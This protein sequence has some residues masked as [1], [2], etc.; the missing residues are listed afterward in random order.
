MVDYLAFPPREPDFYTRISLRKYSRPLPF[1]SQPK[2]KTE[3][4]IRLPIPLSLS[5]SYN[6]DVNNHEYGML[7]VKDPYAALAAGDTKADE[8]MREMSAAEGFGVGRVLSNAVLEVAALMPGV[9]D[10]GFG[11]TAQSIK[12]VVRNPHLTTIFEGVK[13]RAFSF[14]WKLA[15]KSK[16]EAREINN[17]IKTLK[18]YMH[19]QIIAGGFALDYPYIAAMEIVNTSSII[20][21]VKDSFITHLD[22]SNS[23]A[24]GLAFFEDGQPVISELTLGFQ[25]I[26]ILTRDD[27]GTSSNDKRVLESAGSSMFNGDRGR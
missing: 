21:Q 14:T 7:G 27:F 23:A 3:K 25:E 8:F 12:G 9:S 22:I 5:D 17:I 1:T 13:L 11:K 19:P 4:V 18:M 2:T 6:I 20:P 10:S 16:D 26:D 15:P 24:G